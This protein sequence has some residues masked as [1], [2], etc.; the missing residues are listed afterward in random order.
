MG[1]G[2]LQRISLRTDCHFTHTHHFQ[3]P[4]ASRCS[5]EHQLIIR[6]RSQNLARVVD[7]ANTV[8]NNNQEANIAADPARAFGEQGADVV[9]ATVIAH[10]ETI[11]HRHRQI[12]DLAKPTHAV[13]LMKNPCRSSSHAQFLYS[14]KK[15]AAALPPPAPLSPFCR[16][17]FQAQSSSGWTVA[18]F[19][20]PCNA[21]YA[22]PLHF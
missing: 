20:L 13:T 15:S 21:I 5:P 12:D 4:S 8:T 11:A 6:L 18:T 3:I 14:R 22:A 10:W 16:L 19:I 7:A 2:A 17:T 1:L 9:E